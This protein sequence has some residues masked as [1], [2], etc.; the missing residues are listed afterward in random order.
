ME[1][2]KI[3][4]K[5][6]GVNRSVV[7][8]PENDSLAEVLRRYGM[9]GVKVGCGKGQCGACNVI[10]N[11]KLV[12]SCVR[13]MRTVEEWSE[14]ETIEGMGTAENLHPL[15]QA[16]ITYGGVQCGFC[17][18]GFIVSANAL[19]RENPSPSRIEVRAWFQRNRNVCRCTGYKP[20]VDAV[21]AA[22]E[23]MR[24]E[25]TMQDITFKVDEKR[26]VYNTALPRPTALGKVLGLLDYGDD[27]KYHMPPD[28]LHVAII[29]PRKVSHAQIL[30]I[31]YSKAEEMTGVV[32]V[33][34]AKDVKGSNKVTEPLYHPR[35]T[36]QG[37]E[38]PI[39]NDKKIFRYGDIV[40]VV[41]A[42]TEAHAR[43]AAAAVEVK[44]SPLPE[45][46]N[47]LDA[48]APDAVPVHES[49]PG[50]IY[51]MT[52]VI[53][54]EDTRMVIDDSFCTAEG[55]FHTPREPHLSVEGDV[56]QGYWDEDGNMVIQCKTQSMEWNRGAI[57]DAVGIPMEKLR[58][59]CN[60]AGGSFGWSTAAAGYA[61]MGACLMAVDRPLTLTLTYEEFMH[62]SGKR[63]ASYSNGRMAC[64]ENGKLTAIEFD[65]GLDHGPYV[66]DSMPI[67]EYLIRYCGF[68]YCIP[69]VRGLG[70]LAVSNHNFGC[71][72]RGLGSPQV[73]T[74]SESLVDMLAEKMCMD[75]FEF[76]YLNVGRPGDLTINSRPYREI[77]L[78]QLMN[79]MRPHYEEA[80]KRIA[81]LK[82]EGK[83]C[84]VGVCVGGFNVSTG[85]HDHAEVALELNADGSITHYNTWEDM[86][87][88]GD[89]GTLVHT[90][91][92]LKPLGIPVEKIRLLLNDSQKCPDTGIAA[93]SRSHFMAGNAT[94]DAANKL[95]DAMRK[96]D[97]TYRS[98]SEMVAEGI[99]TKY[100]GV[101]DTTGTCEDLNYNT[102][103]GDP[104]PSLT[105]GV[106]LAE[107]EV[108]VKTGKT[109]VLR[110]VAV[111]DV[112][113]VGNLLSVE[114]Q[115]YGGI[116]HTIGYALK[117]DYND[118]VKSG[119][120]AGAGVPYIEDIPDD[121]QLF[122]YESGRS[123][124]PHGSTGCSELFQC[125]G[126]MA[127]LNAINNA[128][129]VRVYDLPA[130]PEKLKALI[131]AKAAGKDMT[132]DK[133]FMGS[134][135]FDTLEEMA[136]NPV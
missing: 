112:G 27:V 68:P 73:Y 55:S 104:T 91:E 120:I 9:L 13:K 74:C 114:G 130:T 65:V 15:Q 59:I 94:I 72:Y 17:S 121:I 124:G 85:G 77:S 63:T 2:R 51:M 81:G 52:P 84:G 30:S 96:L 35:A 20:L 87:Q 56:M 86:G 41:I 119:T 103:E 83:I 19:L 117:E 25:K 48:V 33:V 42:D 93:A 22:A 11:G 76:R 134:E 32:K 98:Y 69:N 102:G 131:E 40:G 80:K 37:N 38:R 21:M 34:T 105:Y 5:L 14:I 113:V 24:G 71:A 136:N 123:L 39:F 115:A 110:E 44:L 54:G 128:V 97:G 6:N 100:L 64:D 75:P 92:A 16:W 58:L 95:M 78:E 45:N 23:V 46:L 18:P 12:R 116:S 129:G 99:A 50:N 61:V 79:M 26:G 31:D 28:T 126:H 70:R 3:I 53:K 111:A 125:S 122:F 1:L 90:H 108:D 107:V 66:N 60:P 36:L 127:V 132:P 118:L 47:Y 8:D 62:F 101:Y 29:Q 4:L 89:I 49:S 82:A 133:F 7:F 57:A 10:L 135:L 106:F 88:G 43:A 67:L 109:T